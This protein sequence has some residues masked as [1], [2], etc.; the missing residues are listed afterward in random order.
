MKLYEYQGRQVFERLGIPTPKGVVVSS[1]DEL[2][3]VKDQL[4]YPLVVK[5]QVLVGGRGKAGGIQF[6][7]NW[8]QAKAKTRQV[9]GMNIKGLTVEKVFLV[10]KLDFAKELYC[11]VLLDR[12][13]RTPMVLFSEE[14]GVEIEAV[15]DEKIKRVHVSHITGWQ[16]YHTRKLFQGSGLKPEV[17]KQVNEIVR[18][19]VAGYHT[20]D[21]E[22]LEINPMAVTP[23]G[24][25]YAADAKVILDDDAE[26]R[27]TEF[28]AAEEELTPLEREAQEKGIA[29]IQLDGRIGIIA[30]GAG[31]TMATLDAIK[32]YGGE[33]GIFLDLGG[34]DNPEKVRECV[35]LMRKA[36]PTVMLLNLFGGITK[37]DTV[38]KGL[39]MVIDSEKIEFPIVTR[40]K[41]V[42]E[43]EARAIVKEAG[44]YSTNTLQEAAKLT[45][46]IEKLAVA[47]KPLPPLTYKVDVPDLLLA[48]G[49]KKAKGAKRTTASKVVR[50]V[51]KAIKG[52]PKPKAKAKSNSKGGR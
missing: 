17:Q 16:A 39:K 24:K 6:A 27:H 11:S 22:L 10:Q 25:V 40:I 21:A 41:G 15:A 13:S 7:D 43:E 49:A 19:L 28:P 2:E 46:E 50:A 14:G 8:E 5:A 37:S 32:H 48:R 18:K 30:N 42:N 12:S 38:A 9:L 36:N 51:K 1:M 29:F 20:M 34:T 33:P 44:L 4:V 35:L 31:L 52:K 26:W 3:K 45:V 23:D 47:G